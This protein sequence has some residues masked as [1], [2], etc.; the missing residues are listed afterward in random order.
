MLQRNKSL[1]KPQ[2]A[3]LDSSAIIALLKKEAGYKIIEDVIATSSMSSVNF[4]EVISVLARSNVTDSDINEII[5]D[6]IPEIIPFT[7]DISILAGKLI[8]VTNIYGLSLG[9]R[10]CIATGIIHNFKILTTDKAWQECQIPNAD[11]VLIR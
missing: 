1:L 4:S 2:K 11:I 6:L 5:A 8:T 9:D 7:Q 10:A 3:L